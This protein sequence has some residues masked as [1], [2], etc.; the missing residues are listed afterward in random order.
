MLRYLRLFGLF[1]KSSVLI[2][3]EYRANFIAQIIL[4]TLWAGVSVA[5][6][7]LVFGQ[8]ASLGGWSLDQALIVVGLFTIFDGFLESLV[9][10]NVQRLIAD[11]RNGAFDFVLL[12]PAN[13]QFMATLRHA[14]L[15][16]ITDAAVGA[17]IIV[18]ACARMGLR[19]GVADIAQFGATAAMGMLILYAIQMAMATTA[20]WFVKV[21]NFSEAFR[22]VYDT[23][24]FPVT[25]FRGAVRI[26]LTF[27]APIAFITTVPAEALLGRLEPAWLAG[28][29]AFGI[30]LFAASAALWRWAVRS[31]SS[32]SS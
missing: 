13:S 3:L 2:E 24:R 22:A 32:A 23:A 26:G 14:R 15:N 21:D 9:L 20:F 12:K 5:T 28:S 25:A 6:L 29:F 4:G 27:V 8:T 31:Y 1:V 19:P 17:A 10:P 16:G 11:I 7:L 30:G 18:Y